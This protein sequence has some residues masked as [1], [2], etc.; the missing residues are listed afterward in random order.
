MNISVRRFR[1]S[2]GERFSVLVDEHGMPLYY[3][4]LFST[5][6]LRA[7]SV[8]ANTVTNALNALKALRAWE[9]ELDI[10]LE[11]DFTQGKFLN[12]NQIRD[13]SDFLQ[14]SLS[15][16]DK[17]SPISIKR[18]PKTVSASVHYYRLSVAA[19]YIE[20]LAHRVAPSAVEALRIKKMSTMIKANRPIRSRKSVPDRD[21][22]RISDSVME[23]L[24]EALKPGSPNNP[25]S[26]YGLQ[27]RNVLMFLILRL[28]GM[29][30]SELLNLRIEDIDFGANTLAVV[31]RPDAKGDTRNHQPVVKTRPRRIYIEPALVAKIKEYVLTQRNKIPGAKKHGYLFITHKSGST[32]GAP[33]SI[34]AFQ[35]LMSKLAAIVEGSGFHAHA[36]RHEWNYQF[37]RMADAKG[38]GPEEEAKVRSYIMG[39]SETSESALHYNRRRIKEQAWEASVELQERYF[40]GLKRT[41]R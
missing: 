32:Q 21:E 23:V 18:K 6:S 27:L 12:E 10:D 2:N 5:W 4:T 7:R 38:M 22:I 35:K 40:N 8:A 17:Q 41:T 39:W 28:T 1:G 33:L 14:R 31:R 37:S 3:A 26:E 11:R 13:L 25:A 36:L 16:S 24:D 15:S 20:F 34:S 30:R 29:R 9:A 19:S